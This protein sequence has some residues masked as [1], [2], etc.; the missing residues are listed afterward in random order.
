MDEVKGLI[1]DIQSFSVHD[2]PG[3]RTTVF[4]MGCP[5]RCEWCANPEGMQLKQ[6]MIYRATKCVHQARGCVRCAAACPWQAI[7]ADKDSLLIDWNK[8]E[9]CTT[10]ECTR[11]CLVE[12]MVVC[13]KW[14]TVA[15]LMKILDRDRR[16]WSHN[17]GV[18]FSGGD[19]LLQPDFLA[20]MLKRCR[21]AYIH[22]AVETSACFPREWFLTLMQQV[23]FAFI[24]IKHMDD[25]RHR[26]QT[27]CSNR[28]TL[29]NVAALAATPWQGR[30]VVR[31]PVIPGF[32]D[33]DENIAATARFVKAAGIE[34]INLLPFHRMGDSKWT[35]CGLVYPYKEQESPPPA[36]LERLQ[37]LVS[38]EGVSCYVGSE[39]P[40]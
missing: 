24:D 29:A 9:A 5:L 30:L 39:T 15:D 14:Y 12:A 32:N 13:G 7:G 22:T 2:G 23:D 37:R 10:H 11:A 26:D 27:G 8:C 6:R 3:C 34:E 17:G 33:T 36:T 19:A 16:Y 20:A 4:F 1:F 21:D 35:Q 38:G 40:F 25:G 31:I 28:Q 18:T